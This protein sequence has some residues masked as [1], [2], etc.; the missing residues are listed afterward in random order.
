M[1]RKNLIKLLKGAKLDIS[2]IATDFYWGE[3][4]RGI[5]AEGIYR[6]ASDA[7]DRLDRIILRL[8]KGEIV[9]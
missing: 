2:V 3:E 4:H 9:E 1:K 5:S 6:N 7:Y 8:E